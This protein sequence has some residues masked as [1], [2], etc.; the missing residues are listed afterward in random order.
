[1]KFEQVTIGDH[2]DVKHGYAFKGKYFTDAGP[3]I[4]VTPGNF[5]E[6]GGFRYR[7]GKEKFYVGEFPESFLLEKDDLIIAM[8][9]QGPGLLGSSAMV[10]EE[11]RF[12]H[13]QRIGLVTN[14]DESKL[15][16]KFLYYLL[17]TRP[18]RGQIEGSATGSK[19]KHTAP[20][21]IKAVRAQIPPL[22]VQIRIA[23]ILTAHESLIE[24][25]R[26]RV[27]LLEE[28]ALHL[29]D[30]WFVRLNFPGSR[31]NQS[32]EQLVENSDWNY[33]P[34]S[35][36]AQFVNG[37]AFKPSH[38]GTDGL[39][40]V[41]I[42]ELVNGVSNKTPRNSGDIVPAK[43]HIDTGSLLF[44]WSANL[45]VREWSDGPALLNQHLF[46]VIPNNEKTKR[47]LMLALKRALPLF[48]N[49]STGATMKH[50]RRSALDKV[51]CLLPPDSVLHA[52]VARVDHCWDQI[53]VL[54]KQIRGL[55]A[56]R[57]LLLPRLMSGEIEV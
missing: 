6:G 39:P 28:A 12:L 41:K 33:L 46:H 26:S 48:M 38:L 8:T 10:P 19:V 29:Y 42:P 51:F 40:I 22:N 52:F 45:Q 57:D 50:I 49:Q 47:F 20:K 30:E 54:N 37:F 1:M 17:N 25:C 32:H 31:D 16:K 9:Q 23:E 53:T 11:K 14:L 2:F 5:H 21:R 27:A 56:S 7:E 44:S 3:F 15:H 35:E 13:N 34:F 24:N 36:I 43:N 18:V 4:V 55:V